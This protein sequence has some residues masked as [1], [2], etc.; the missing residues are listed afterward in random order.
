[1]ENLVTDMG[2]E[3]GTSLSVDKGITEAGRRTYVIICLS[4]KQK[5]IKMSVM[6]LSDVGVA[7][8]NAAC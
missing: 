1:M 4:L 5:F 7:V 3:R 8:L 2:I 6:R